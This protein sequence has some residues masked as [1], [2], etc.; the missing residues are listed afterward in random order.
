M[1]HRPS[2]LVA[3]AALVAG[4]AGPAATAAT[5]VMPA[6]VRATTV[7]SGPAGGRVLVTVDRPVSVAYDHF[8]D[9]KATGSRFAGVLV[10]D[11]RTGTWVNEVVGLPSTCAFGDASCTSVDL[12]AVA[13]WR[14]NETRHP[15]PR[16]TIAVTLIGDPG[17]R[18][19]ATLHL[20]GARTGTARFAARQWGG[21]R[22][23]DV[24]ST[25]PSAPGVQPFTRGSATLD[26]V[27]APT[28]TG[29]VVRFDS[30]H[31]HDL[32]YHVCVGAAA[33]QVPTTCDD[34]DIEESG[35]VGLNECIVP[36]CLP[37]ITGPFAIS[38]PTVA[39]RVDATPTLTA[40]TTIVAARSRA[41]VIAYG[42]EL[43]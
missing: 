37:V 26:G 27:A 25:V 40:E 14:Y 24:V 16:G 28:V 20:R 22:V 18:V 1:R 30:D 35:G 29:A 23:R 10:S 15:L 13:A 4:V 17:S 42:V 7:V 12:P 36:V 2:H 34:R 33:P 3:A 8:A 6:P 43:G 21:L 5:P 11:L 31:T 39:V 9:L 32:G 19:T 41:Q 38:L